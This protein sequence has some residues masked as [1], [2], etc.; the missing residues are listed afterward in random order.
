MPSDP[1]SA[2]IPTAEKLPSVNIF[3]ER[4]A[5][6]RSAVVACLLRD[7][8]IVAGRYSP[9]FRDLHEDLFIEVYHVYPPVWVSSEGVLHDPED[10]TH[11]CPLPEA[12]TDAR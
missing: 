6:P 2:W 10:V 1:K 4:R 11:W 9:R 8:R 3:F 7:R 5:R 12:P